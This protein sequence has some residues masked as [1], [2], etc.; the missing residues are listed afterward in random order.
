MIKFRKKVIDT[1]IASVI[2]GMAATAS[3]TVLAQDSGSNQEIDEVVVTGSKIRRS[4]DSTDSGQVI[5][6]DAI[7]IEAQGQLSMADVLRASPLNA[8]GSFNER[9]GSSAQSNSNINLRGL[10]ANRTLVLVN[11]RRVPGSPNTGAASANINMLPQVA[12]QRTDILADGASSVY[13]SD[14]MAGVVNLLLHDD[15][16]GV[17]FKV[18]GADRT[19]DDGD[20]TGFSVLAGISNDKANITIAIEASNR[21]PVFDGDRDYTSAKMSDENGDGK[22]SVN[23]NE[24][25]GIST[26]G[27]TVRLRDTTT[28]YSKYLAAKDC[29]TTDGF[30]GVLDY[31]RNLNTDIGQ[32]ACGYAYANISANKAGLDKINTYISTTYELTDN[33]EFYNTVLFARNES[34]GR[35]APPAA[36]WRPFPED[37]P[38]NPHNIDDLLASGDITE[39]NY[40]LDGRYRWTAIGPR[41]NVV[42]DVQYDI[43]TGFRGDINDN[44][45]YDV[46]YQYNRYTSKEFGTYYLNNL[47]LADVV[48]KG[49][50]PFGADAGKTRA[51]TSQDNLT[52]LSNLSGEF[53]IDLGDVMGAGDAYAL[54][55]FSTGS[56][57]YNNQYD[58][59]S[60]AGL[61][62][63]SAGN[64]SAGDRDTSALF[65][66]L[67][68]PIIDNLEVDVSARYDSYSDFGTIVTP[69]LGIVFTGVENLAL[70]FNYNA[71]FRAPALDELYGPQTFSAEDATDYV[72]CTKANTPVDKCS[73]S[74]FETYSRTNPD[75]EPETSVGI[76]FGADY[77]LSSFVSSFSRF[78][79]SLGY[80]DIAIDN[81]IRTWSTQ[82]LIFAE[83][84]GYNF[85]GTTATALI[86]VERESGNEPIFY[87]RST[88]EGEL[89]V[90]GIDFQIGLEIPFNNS[91]FSWDTHISQQLSYEQTVY[92]G[93][94]AQ[95][96]VG[97][98]EQPKTKL[99]SMFGLNLFD[100]HQIY[101]TYNYT[102]E[103]PYGSSVNA[104][105]VLEINDGGNAEAWATID[106]SYQYDMKANGV[107]KLGIRN[108][109]DEDPVLDNNGEFPRAYYNLYD[110][111]GQVI[112]L[113]YTI[114]F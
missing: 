43:T 11:G 25:I 112:Y 68:L 19:R 96:T 66:E 107:V 33:V 9:S 102:G 53:Q 67:I 28:G 10:G 20:E 51:T 71:G 82:A 98:D 101:L 77:D 44:I 59:A 2:T 110:P 73:T 37:N 80:Y 47:G 90:S 21:D 12:V 76:S 103:H 16:E 63:G 46:S 50:D 74:Q 49:G 64:S 3:Y 6:M 45:T 22:I 41:D 55:G 39:G 23:T 54:L 32:T 105:G 92:P 27:K 113:D 95:D 78:D 5:S 111:S 26:F 87:S 29:S 88:N 18:H 48:A 89:G 79:I 57:E 104:Q 60:E 36:W 56:I 109:T 58:A 99:Q 93:A 8:Y 31:D 70:R 61:I 24:A 69:A 108:L 72:S 7:Q 97:F 81:L 1:A 38:T 114:E 83:Q 94:A 85:T 34:F 15:Y 14:A 84:G 40:V 17:K 13:G 100:E 91:S 62:G 106:L 75:L 52:Y 35:Y 4:I 86:F 30:V 65:A 42:T